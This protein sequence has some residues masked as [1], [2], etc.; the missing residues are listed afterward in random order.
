MDAS[1]QRRT[2]NYLID[3]RKG[4]G[5]KKIVKMDALLLQIIVTDHFTKPTKQAA[6]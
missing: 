3:P 5:T 4:P 6:V 2:I 1:N